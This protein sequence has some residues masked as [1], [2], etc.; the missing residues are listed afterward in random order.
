MIAKL[1]AG[2]TRENITREFLVD[3]TQKFNEVILDIGAGDGKGS[4]RKARSSPDSSV[5]A[6]DSSFNALEESSKVA[7]RK[8]SK[9]GVSNL[10]CIYA[11]IKNCSDLLEGIADLVRVYLPWGDLLE[12]IA[13]CNPEIMKSITNSAKH[14]CEIQIVV[15]AQIWKEN[16][17]HNLTH[18]SEVTPHF[19][20]QN[21][22]ILN[23]FGFQLT[24]A[25]EMTK[26]EIELLDT[27]WTHKLL[28]S[29]DTASFIM[30]KG[31]RS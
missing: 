9:G 31:A 12:G 22:E 7:L 10:I 6:L 26:E 21:K 1:V 13:T 5:I 25:Y 23:T 28:S 27:T 11:N 8:P 17:P 30:A 2:K 3:K 16:L 24:H 14:G 18:L 15:N 29:R 4:L 19:F 20:N